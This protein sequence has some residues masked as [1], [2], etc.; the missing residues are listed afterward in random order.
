M[1]DV[2]FNRDPITVILLA[3]G[4]A[5]CVISWEPNK[6]IHY[7]DQLALVMRKSSNVHCVA[8]RRRNR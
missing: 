3:A 4:R 1:R 6:R 8:R 7:N 2:K 5:E